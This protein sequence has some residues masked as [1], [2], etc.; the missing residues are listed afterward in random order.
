MQ[1]Q[2]IQN[3]ARMHQGAEKHDQ[4]PLGGYE[5]GNLHLYRNHKGATFQGGVAG[6][7]PGPFWLIAIRHKDDL[8]PH[9]SGTRRRR[10]CSSGVH[11]GRRECT[12]AKLMLLLPRHAYFSHG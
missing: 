7:T 11:F 12:S 5:H 3:V 4:G 9:R 10:Q 8:P 1:N 2:Q 6:R